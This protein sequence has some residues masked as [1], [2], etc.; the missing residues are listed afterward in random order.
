MSVI[1]PCRPIPFSG[2]FSGLLKV[3]SLTVRKVLRIP[4]P[5]GVNFN[6][7]VQFPPGASEVPQLLLF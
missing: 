6:C 4:V 7:T 5:V 3:L 1:L 2:T